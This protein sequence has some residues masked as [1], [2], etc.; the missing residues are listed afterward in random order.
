[1]SAEGDHHDSLEEAIEDLRSLAD[2]AEEDLEQR[3]E[4]T[5]MSGVDPA[6]MAVAE[7]QGKMQAFQKAWALAIDKRDEE[8]EGG[9]GK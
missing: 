4:E 8:P 6:Q 7:M 2:Q 9:L 5:D 1:M 3:K